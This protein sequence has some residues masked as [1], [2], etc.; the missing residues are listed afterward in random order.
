MASTILGIDIGSKNITFVL[1]KL[2]KEVE[3]ISN[4]TLDTPNGAIELGELIKPDEIGNLIKTVILEKKIKAKELAICINSPEVIIREFSVPS[5]LKDSELLSAL[6]FEVNKTFKSIT[7]THDISFKV[8]EKTE[9]TIDGILC[10]CPKSLIKGYI[11]I[12][13]LQKIPLKYLDVSPN[14]ISK[15]YE[16]FISPNKYNKTLAIVDIGSNTT[17]VNIIC[18]GK[19]KMSRSIAQGGGYLDKLMTRTF[20]LSLQE[21]EKIK[22]N[23]I[24]TFS[25]NNLDFEFQLKAAYDS[26]EE[27]ILNTINYYMKASPKNTA[28]E[29][30]Y[31]VGG[32]SL[33][34]GLEER[35][36][37]AF[38]IETSILKL[39]DSSLRNLSNFNR[40]LPA[41]GA[42]IREE[43]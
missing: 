25:E 2:G 13:E 10:L 29:K 24:K 37:N 32:G 30:I 43:V 22:E 42:A 31:L 27:E 4:F 33:T 1:V 38:K 35:F 19:L 41:L 6:E 40:I 9:D 12:G 34:L 26:I 36:A 20:D 15:V 39:G 17:T 23:H 14:C 21:A 16:E 8:Y 18:K 3:I 28:V 7:T 11:E 5:S